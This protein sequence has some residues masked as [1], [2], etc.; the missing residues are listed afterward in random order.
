MWDTA[1]VA[2]VLSRYMRKHY[3]VKSA[4][5]NLKSL[6]PYNLTKFYGGRDFS[7]TTLTTIG[8]VLKGLTYDI[9]QVHSAFRFVKYFKRVYPQKSVVMH[10]HGED[11]RLVGWRALR[12][13]LGKANLTLVSTPDMLKGAPKSVYWLPNPV[14]TGHF[15][16]VPNLRKTG[17]ALYFVKHQRGEDLS[18]PRAIARKYGLELCLHDR[19]MQPIVY[20]ELP[21]FLSSF[22]YYIDRNYIASLSKT[23]LEALACK[24]KVID[25]NEEMLDKF[26]AEHNPINV[27]KIL[28]N[29]YQEMP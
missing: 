3:N 4:V 26:P 21:K 27:V 29:L 11:V 12:E 25:S 9:I 2:S 19:V 14:D 8:F 6:D 5:V 16:P 28:W 18:W 13:I 7:N 10:F 1:G 24:V 15:K 23:A 22:E 20:S 17:A